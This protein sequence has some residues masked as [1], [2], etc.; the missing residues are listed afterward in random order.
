MT[1][2]LRRQE[3]ENQSSEIKYMPMKPTLYKEK[4]MAE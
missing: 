4:Q 1:P 3:R 2:I